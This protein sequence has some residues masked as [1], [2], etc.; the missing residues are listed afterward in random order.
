MAAVGIGELNR[1]LGGTRGVAL[2]ILRGGEGNGGK[3]VM[4]DRRGRRRLAIGIVIRLNDTGGGFE[5]GQS[6]L[7]R[8]VE[9]GRTLLDDQLLL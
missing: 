9:R 8:A 1:Q 3:G 5:V 2:G 6:A 7:I 4:R